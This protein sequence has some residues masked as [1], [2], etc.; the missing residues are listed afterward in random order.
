MFGPSAKAHRLLDLTLGS[1]VSGLPMPLDEALLPAE[2]LAVVREKTHG[3]QLVRSDT[4]LWLVYSTRHPKTT[5]QHL[6]NAIEPK[7]KVPL[8]A[9][10]LPWAH[11]LGFNGAGTAQ[12]NSGYLHT[13]RRVEVSHGDASAIAVK[14]WGSGPENRLVVAR[15]VDGQQV[16]AH[17]EVADRLQVYLQVQ[18]LPA[19]PAMSLGL[20]EFTSYVG[21]RL[22]AEL[23]WT[24]RIRPD[25]SLGNVNFDRRY[26]LAMV[27]Q[28]KM[29][30]LRTLDWER[31]PYAGEGVVFSP[32][33]VKLPRLDSAV[34]GAGH[35]IGR[36]FRRIGSLWRR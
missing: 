25:G 4:G 35:L 26:S 14:L 15:Q 28:Q 36:G 10:A 1:K 23:Q 27:W 3:L 19:D 17:A 33:V 16:T 24:R 6:G 22:S 13:R 8:P 18:L 30:T 32:L 2:T 31:L 29:Y 34:A 7:Y 11:A 12:L 9:P 21:P 5:R 20:P